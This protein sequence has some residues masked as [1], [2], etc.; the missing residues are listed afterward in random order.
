MRS[1]F[2]K[3]YREKSKHTFYIKC[4]FSP[5]S[6]PFMRKCRK[7]W[8][9]QRGHKWQY[10]MTHPRCMLD[11]QGCM[12]TPTC[13][14]THREICNTYFFSLAT[15]VSRQRHI[16]RCLSLRSNVLLVVL[17]NH[18]QHYVIS[19]RNRVL[20]LI[21]RS[22]FSIHLMMLCLHARHDLGNPLRQSSYW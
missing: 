10:H 5:K 17:S 20:R 18:T 1:F 11:N 3:S 4:L 2:G 12:R 14:Y 19:V 21:A 16:V 22:E 8:W 9:S 7:L 13:T 6:V 15:M